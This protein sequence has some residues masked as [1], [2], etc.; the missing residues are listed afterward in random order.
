MDDDSEKKPKR[1]YEVGYGKP[2]KQHQWKQG[3]SGNK[4]G[5]RAKLPRVL[6]PAQMAQDL[7]ERLERPMVVKTADGRSE[8]M[9]TIM[10]IQ[11]VHI[12]KALAGHAPNWRQLQADYKEL[13]AQTAEKEPHAAR[14]FDHVLDAIA[15]DKSSGL[16]LY[17]ARALARHLR[18]RYVTP[19]VRERAP[20]LPKPYR[21][22]KRPDPGAE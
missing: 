11:E 3:E 14:T 16:S 1:E 13:L 8:T 2:P 6:L 12:R 9:P 17:Y 7:L 22:S 4:K 19:S 15:E 18:R 5:R 21:L 20:R 10:A